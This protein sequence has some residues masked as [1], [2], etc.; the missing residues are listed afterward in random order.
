MAWQKAMHHLHAKTREFLVDQ[1]AVILCNLCE[2]PSCVPGV[3]VGRQGPLSY[4]LQTKTGWE[5]WKRHVD[6]IREVGD[7]GSVLSEEHST[8]KVGKPEVSPSEPVLRSEE[9]LF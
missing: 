4:G 1:H 7:T 2:G 5:V 9:P 6:Q 3:V 8:P